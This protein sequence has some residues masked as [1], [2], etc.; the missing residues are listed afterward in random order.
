VRRLA[1]LLLLLSATRVAAGA[2]I[3]RFAAHDREN[4]FRR[5]LASQELTCAA[6]GSLTFPSGLW[7]VFARD[8]GQLSTTMLVDA[9][10]APV[11]D[12]P[13]LPAAT[14]VAQLPPERTAVV[15]ATH[16]GNAFPIGGDATLVPAAEPLWLIVLENAKPVAVLPIA[17]I[18][19]GA[20]RNIDARSGGT[21]VLL[22]WIAMPE[23]DRVALADA[24]N[25][26]SPKV[27]MKLLDSEPLP[28]AAKLHG[29]FVLVRGVAAGE[30]D[31]DLSGHR[32][33]PFRQRVKIGAQP[34]TIAESPLVARGAA[35]VIVN[36]SADDKV[37]AQNR[38]IPGC[39]E[40]KTPPQFE[41]SLVS[42]P[43]PRPMQS[44]DPSTCRVV[45]TQTFP[46]HPLDGSFT[47]EDVPPAAYR[48]EL[49][50]GELPPVGSSVKA[51]P[52][53]TANV[54][55]I[56][57]YND[58]YGSVTFGGEPLG[59]NAAIEFAGNGIAF[60]TKEKSEY[61]AAV[62]EVVEVDAV[63]NIAACDDPFRAFVLTDRPATRMSRLDI[64]I[65]D[66]ELTIAVVDTFTQ[67]T[68]PNVA[69]K[70]AVMSKYAGWRAV[71]TRTVSAQPGERDSSV[72]IRS[73]PE[74]TLRITVS[75]P[76][77]QK[78][79]L[80]PFTMTKSERKRIDVKLMPQR[81]T[82]GRIVSPMPFENAAISW[83]S[84]A[85]AETEHADVSP[86]GTFVYGRAHDGSET[87]AVVSQSHPLWV[88]HSPAVARG[89]T[90]TLQFPN[91][92]PVDFEV[93]LRGGDSREN[94]YV[95]IVVGGVRVPMPALQQHASFRHGQ[96]LANSKRPLLITQIAQTGPIEILL[97]PP[98]DSI[99]GRWLGSDFFAL[100]QFA[101]VPRQPLP[102]GADAVVFELP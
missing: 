45:R 2:E 68:V 35:T 92:P 16:S 55:V 71:L 75:A 101:D 52:F 37:P 9:S 44:L 3:C 26:A 31:L 95:A 85:G 42:C 24:R 7:N 59:K 62:R 80:E 81:G 66:N 4:P 38:D 43:P 69:V 34:V 102:P 17:P 25:I 93:L 32:W 6:D 61:R 60:A 73:L 94:R 78:T 29:A 39:A 86:D 14:L 77:Y 12:L 87:L 57:S 89:G 30:S 56:A 72:V 11:L 74:R 83:F 58:L 67:M 33:L 41:L 47:I 18:E 100:P 46:A 98:S 53:K 64:D 96:S 99:P 48:A 13:L 90:M 20:R 36:W 65:P 50:F 63:I 91:V 8:N 21:G 97:G 54:R 22:T 5:W 76:G 28:D 79:D 19:A 82:R 49:K 88:L 84:A 51:E 70:Y 27:R 15:Y 1:A 23:A 40:S 10:S